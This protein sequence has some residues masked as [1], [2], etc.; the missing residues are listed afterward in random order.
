MVL[1]WGGG[2]ILDT[3]TEGLMDAAKGVID[4][5]VKFILKA[6][7][8]LAGKAATMG[9]A[10]KRLRPIS[11]KEAIAA[12]NKALGERDK[13]LQD[14]DTAVEDRDR[15]IRQR[16]QARQ[17]AKAAND[18]ANQMHH[19]RNIMS[20]EASR[21]QSER[22]DAKR[23]AARQGKRAD[24]AEK[25]IARLS[26]SDT[27]IESLTRKQGSAVLKIFE[28]TNKLLRMCWDFMERDSTRKE[29]AFGIESEYG[30]TRVGDKTQYRGE[31]DEPIP[32]RSNADYGKFDHDC[33][34]ITQAIA[35]QCRE[36]QLNK[37]IVVD[38]ADREKLGSSLMKKAEDLR[39]YKE[40]FEKI[41]DKISATGFGKE[42]VKRI[43]SITKN[44]NYVVSTVTTIAASMQKSICVDLGKAA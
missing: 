33:E 38:I 2:A 10:I 9:A 12:M 3:A 36:A 19:E 17:D 14:R 25:E 4:R 20:A 27:M 16:D 23:D 43:N 39:E 37:C 13:A 7:D 29:K 28:E 15:A 26:K 18:T 6:I 40:K 11:K 8:F 21:T 34:R 5:I 31:D 41:R 1:K 32:D 42:K 22:D 24:E 30:H 35:E 44:L